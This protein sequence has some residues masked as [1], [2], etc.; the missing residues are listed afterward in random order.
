MRQR[1]AA[2]QAGL[3][4]IPYKIVKPTDI[5]PGSKK[6]WAEAFKK[7]FND[8]RNVEAGGI[9]PNGGL[10]SQPIIKQ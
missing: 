6:T 3:K 2:Q 8:V 7:R 10:K 4:K 9:V 5:M 1:G